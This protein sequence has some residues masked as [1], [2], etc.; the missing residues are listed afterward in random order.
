MSRKDGRIMKHSRAYSVL[1]GIAVL[2]TVVGAF[3]ALAGILP[4]ATRGNP[5][6]LELIAGSGI[7]LIGLVFIVLSDIGSRLYRIEAKLGTLP[8]YDF[9]EEKSESDRDAP[10]DL[11]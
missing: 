6:G 11:S 1:N 7:A 8:K 10:A 3:T 2:L 5:S 4:V 9:G